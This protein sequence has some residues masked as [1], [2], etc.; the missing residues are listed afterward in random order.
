MLVFSF[1]CRILY[2]KKKWDT[3]LR[4]HG[5]WKTGQVNTWHTRHEKNPGRKHNG[6]VPIGVDKNGVRFVK[7]FPYCSFFVLF[8]FASI[9]T[10]TC[11]RFSF[12]IT[13]YRIRSLRTRTIRSSL[14]WTTCTIVRLKSKD[15]L[16]RQ[17]KRYRHD[18]HELFLIMKKIYY[19]HTRK[20]THTHTWATKI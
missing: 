9:L 18:T 13:K 4:P 3:P 12:Y 8:E 17:R 20:Y 19:T 7:S 1:R 14:K 2:R 16:Q 10:H 6:F 5:F 15:K 11:A